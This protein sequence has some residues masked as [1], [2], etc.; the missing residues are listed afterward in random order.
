MQFSAITKITA[1]RMVVEQILDKIKSG[2][3]KPGDKLPSQM[4][5]TKLFQVGRTSIREAIKALDAMGYLDVIQGKGTFFKKII[6]FDDLYF[7]G[8]KKALEAV[9]LT[10]L[11]CTREVLECKAAE[12]ASISPDPKKLQH[13][14]EAIKKLSQIEGE[15][16][17]FIE[18]DLEFH[19]ALAEASGNILLCEILKLIIEKVHRHH[20]IYFSISSILYKK[21][22]DTANKILY[23]IIK[24]DGE[25]AAACV[26]YH[27]TVVSDALK[28][29]VSEKTS[30]KGESKISDNIS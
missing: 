4:E 27:L 26:R 22:I 28:D 17:S 14:Q 13:L 16:K 2:E 21:T 24:G 25:N 20:L 8:L 7:I 23:H 6:S 15:T 11:M 12:L 30:K 3:I 19:F 10:D 9:N 5:L 18:A 29:T 1:S